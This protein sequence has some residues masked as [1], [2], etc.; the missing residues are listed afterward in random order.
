MSEAIYQELPQAVKRLLESTSVSSKAEQ[1]KS[2]DVFVNPDTYVGEKRS[3]FCKQVAYPG[4]CLWRAVLS[5]AQD[6]TV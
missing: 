5:P 6:S 3:P 4:S 2:Q 1:W